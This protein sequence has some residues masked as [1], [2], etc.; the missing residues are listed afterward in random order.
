MFVLLNATRMR[1]ILP[2]AVV[3]LGLMAT[4]WIARSIR[5]RQHSEDLDRFSDAASRLGAN[6]ERALLQYG[7]AIHGVG[8]LFKACRTIDNLAFFGYVKSL[9]SQEY[10]SAVEVWGWLT[11]QRHHTTLA[12]PYDTSLKEGILTPTS[13]TNQVQEFLEFLPYSDQPNS[14][15]DGMATSVVGA[16]LLGAAGLTE[17][18]WNACDHQELR[19][20]GVPDQAL[21]SASRGTVFLSLPIYRERTSRNSQTD[22]RGHLA[23]WAVLG[24]DAQRFAAQVLAIESDGLALNLWDATESPRLLYPTTPSPSIT[25]GSLVGERFVKEVTFG[26]RKWIIEIL[27][28]KLQLLN[29]GIAAEY[30]PAGISLLCTLFLTLLTSLI[31]NERTNAIKLASQL[32]T[33]NRQLESANKHTLE[34]MLVAQAASRAKSDF[35]AN[36][37][38]EIRTPMTAILGYSNLLLQQGTSKSEQEDFVQ[39]IHRNGNHLLGIIDDILDISKIE[40][41]KMAVERIPC[42]PRQLANEAISLMQVSAIAK[43]LSLQIEYRGAIPE[44]IQSDPTRLRQILINLLGNAVK[45]TKVGG[46]R[47]GVRLLDPPET[48]NPHLGFEVIDTGVGMQPEQLCSLFQPFTQADT[49]MTRR[50]GGT[51]LGLAISKRLAQMLGGDITGT[52]SAG[53]GSSFLVSIE[54]GPLEGVRIS[55]GF[56]EALP[57]TTNPPSDKQVQDIRLSARVLLAED[58]LDNQRFITF[59]LK[60]AGVQIT[61]ADNGQIALDC[62]QSAQEEGNPFDVILMDMQMPVLDGYE[63]TR[64]LRA[65]GYTGPIIA[66]TAHAMAEDR[67]KCLDAGCDDY[68]TKPIERQ[69]LLKTVA[70]WMNRDRK[71]DLPIPAPSPTISEN[72][73]RTAKPTTSESNVSRAKPTAFIYSQLASDPNMVELVDLFVQEIPNRINALETQAQSRDW[74]QLTRTAHQIK[75]AAGSYGFGE[76]TPYAAR[77]E[78]AAKDGCREEEILSALDEL[79]GLC[80]QVRSGAPRTEVVRENGCSATTS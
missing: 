71:N 32:Q 3:L 54:T 46:V 70:Q 40:S 63:A 44:T 15:Y 47:L 5:E 21:G 36:M 50:F 42:S 25:R 31:V 51:G 35:L 59:V 39:I 67:Q 72:N 23:G 30:F 55:D 69:N 19:L 38:H 16:D 6:T 80:R 48:P 52:S 43:S 10:Y 14:S 18:F 34:A 27:P 29:Y 17:V 13:T 28:G 49:S 9:A 78:A 37:S 57:V 62:V 1:V 4:G 75:G 20:S 64:R 76:I 41:G 65:E 26:G 22:L 7:A 56:R 58:G 33:T 11:P 68:A 12:H 66:L 2:L 53:K 45:F 24:I 8:S 74:Q 73:A 60:K 77:L 61:V 79:L